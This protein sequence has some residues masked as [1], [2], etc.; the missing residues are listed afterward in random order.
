MIYLSQHRNILSD[1]ASPG[2]LSWRKS[3][4]VQR[5]SFE[6]LV[7]L[8]VLSFC[9]IFKK[10]YPK[11]S[12]DLQKLLELS[13]KISAYRARVS[14]LL[15]CPPGVLVSGRTSTHYTAAT[16]RIFNPFEIL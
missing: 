6:K 12:A 8:S 16:R 7:I 15:R 5:E 10:S 13:I 9:Q 1:A 14:R 4:L 3:L 11:I 2:N